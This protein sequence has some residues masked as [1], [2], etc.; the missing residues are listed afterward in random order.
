MKPPRQRLRPPPASAI[1]P[2]HGARIPARSPAAEL[3]SPQLLVAV[4]G[5]M[6][7]AA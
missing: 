5:S 6:P 4:A 3:T 7:T 2:S 1:A